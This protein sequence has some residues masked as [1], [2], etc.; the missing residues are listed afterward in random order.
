[1][2]VGNATYAVWR[3]PFG[4]TS[5]TPVTCNVSGLISGDGRRQEVCTRFGMRRSGCLIKI[6]PKGKR[7][8]YWRF[9]MR[10][11]ESTI[12]SGEIAK[13]TCLRDLQE[14]AKDDS[15]ADRSLDITM[16]MHRRKSPATGHVRE[17]L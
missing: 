4:Q 16:E 14:P 10:M 11:K 6:W 5:F 13:T 15:C 3:V 8:T 17:S 12:L 2:S 9:W 7:G 1:M